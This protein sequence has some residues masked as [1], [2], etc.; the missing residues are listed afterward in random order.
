MI[1]LPLKNIRVIDITNSWSGP[2]TAQLLASM[3]AETIKVESIQYLD[4]WRAGG[5]MQAEQNMIWERSPLWN[6]VNTDKYGTTL[7]LTDMKGVEIFKK[8][9]KT[10]DIVV[11][12]YSPRVMKNF[13]LDY[14]VLK[15]INPSIIMISLPAYGSTGPWRDYVG[16]AASIEQMAGI[17]DS[18]NKWNDGRHVCSD[19]STDDRR[20]AI[21]R[22]FP[23]RGDHLPYR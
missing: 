20:R 18:R 11:E 7:N 15:E 9:V 4:T 19:S 16:F 2:Y 23:D 14:P 3:G 10:S 17:P 13:G 1:E 6:S 12:N 21:H 22:P 8:L 5:T